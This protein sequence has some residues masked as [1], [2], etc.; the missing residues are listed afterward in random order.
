MLNLRHSSDVDLSVILSKTMGSV[1]EEYKELMKPTLKQERFAQNIFSGM[2]QTEAYQV[3][4]K[5][6]SVAVAAVDASRLLRKANI[7]EYI[8]DLG[9]QIKKDKVMDKQER[10]ERLTEI[11]RARLTDYQEL[12]LDSGYISIGKESP[13]TAAIAGIESA[14]KFDE[15]GNTGILFT[16]VK[17]LNPMTAIDLLNKM[18]NLYGNTTI[19]IDNRKVEVHLLSDEQLNIIASGS[20]TGVIEQ[21]AGAE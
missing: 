16:K 1:R 18:D 5:C 13:N 8:A 3:V 15:N 17:L 10:Y 6:K 2:N 7:K 21:T 19:N 20:G 9:A 12:G 4:Y 14:T 11:A